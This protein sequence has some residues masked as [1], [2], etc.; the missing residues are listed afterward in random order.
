MLCTANSADP[1]TVSEG[2]QITHD[3]PD[4]RTLVLWVSETAVDMG[5]FD[6]PTNVS[7]ETP[8]QAIIVKYKDLPHV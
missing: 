3:L 1:G 8:D 4:G 6:G 2:F 7:N 5:V